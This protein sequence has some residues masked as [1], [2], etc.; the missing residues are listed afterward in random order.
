LGII[1]LIATTFDRILNAALHLFLVTMTS[2]ENAL[3]GPLQSV[4][5]K[6]ALQTL[7]LMMIPV[8]TIVAVVKLFGGIVRLVVV[9]ILVLVLAHILYPLV[10]GTAVQAP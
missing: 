2:L 7:I 3:R 4:G 6:G 9:V 1:D 8:L 5:I 10:A